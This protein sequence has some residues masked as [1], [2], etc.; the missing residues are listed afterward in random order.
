MG[1]YHFVDVRGRKLDLHGASVGVSFNGA[2][3]QNASVA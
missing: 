1:L 3:P 2:I